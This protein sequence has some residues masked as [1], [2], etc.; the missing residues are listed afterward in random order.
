M[1]EKAENDNITKANITNKET[2][3]RIL[4]DCYTSVCAC[5]CLCV[6]VVTNYSDCRRGL[7]WMLDLLT[8]HTQDS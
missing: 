3:S 4:T 2:S 8:T 5:V 1:R 7:D 6:C